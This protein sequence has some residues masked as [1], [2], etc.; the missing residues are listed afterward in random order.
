[1][2]KLLLIILVASFASIINA[3]QVNLSLAQQVAQNFINT[4]SK[5]TGVHSTNAT[6]KLKCVAK[7]VTDN[8]PYYIFN[9]EDGGFVIVSGDDCAT[10]ILGYS[11]E[12]NIDINN[13]PIQLEDLL[14]A[15]ALEIQ[16]SPCSR[17]KKP[18][19]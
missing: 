4:T 15:Y 7:R 9:N 19:R 10:P 5:K 1:M 3:K 6:H 16:V 18:A 8:Q 2:K 14:Q 12:G 11:N 17:A 13:L